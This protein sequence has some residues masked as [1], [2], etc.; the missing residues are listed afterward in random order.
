MKLNEFIA[1]E[2]AML[3]KFESY[4]L[5]MNNTDPETFPLEQ[6]TGDWDEQFEL[7]KFG[8]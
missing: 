1:E 5:K 4:W 3:E 7:C 6:E 8:P 2:R